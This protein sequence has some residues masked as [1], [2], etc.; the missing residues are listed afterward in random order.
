M[1]RGITL[2]EVLVVIV[3]ISIMLGMAIISFQNWRARWSIEADTKDIYAFV[4]KARA[5]AFTQ[6]RDLIVEASGRQV[7]IREGTTVIDC[8]TLNNPFT[9]RISINSRGVLGSS[10]IRYDGSLSVS[11]Q[12][13]CVAAYITRVKMGVRSGSSCRAR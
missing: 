10:N 5:M 9:G 8:I 3:L 4:Q 6:K 1:R 2:I 13:D 11:P 12:Y 7:C